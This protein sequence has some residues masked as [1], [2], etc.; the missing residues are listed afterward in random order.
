ML[1][2]KIKKAAGWLNEKRKVV[3]V[4]R[5]LRKHPLLDGLD[6]CRCRG[7]KSNVATYTTHQRAAS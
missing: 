2:L 4:T 7:E 5:E 6:R 3:E 1:D